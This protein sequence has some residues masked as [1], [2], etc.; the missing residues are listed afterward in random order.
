[1]TDDEAAFTV[2]GAIA[3]QGV[4]L[5]TP[6]LGERFV[7]IGLGLVGLLTVQILRA[8]GC[9]VLGI[10]PDSAKCSLAQRFGADLVR[11]D[12][13]EDPLAVAESFSNGLG[14]DG[15]LIA[16]ATRSNGPIT[17]A[18]RMCR[19]RGRIILVGVVGL[20]LDRNDFYNKEVSFQV[21]CSY[22]PGRYD[23]E[24]ENKG[25]DYPFGFVRWTEQRNFE[26][27]LEMMRL[28]TLDVKSLISHRFPIESASAAYELLGNGSRSQLGIL[29]DY[30]SPATDDREG[31]TVT[32]TT[33]VPHPD[34]R[35]ELSIGFIGAGNYAGRVLIPAFAA[36]DVRLRAIASGKGISA[37]HIGRKF[38]FERATTDTDSLIAATDVDALVIATRHDS[39][40]D[41]VARAL[42]A[43]K[44]VFVEKPLAL[45][46]SEI[47]AIES[48]RAM[49]QGSAGTPHVMVG[50]NRRFAPQIV[51]MKSLLERA[52]D[53]MSIVVTVN[54]GAIP[55]SHWTQDRRVGGGRIIGE[56]CH[57]VDLARFLVA[58]P[59]VDAR[60][61]TLRGN[62]IS[63]RDD[64]ATIN[65]AFRDGS[66]ATIHYLANGHPAF[67]K[68]RIEVFCEG[69]ILQ[70]DN[71][72][73][74][75]GYGWPAFDSMNLWRQ[76]KGQ[77]AC[78]K[79]FVD[80]IRGGGASPIPFDELLEVGRVT[81]ALGEAAQG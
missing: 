32:L 46:A 3:L 44:H 18:A 81:I 78:A 74:L 65:L 41:L 17:Q 51:R 4:R 11:L 42:Q 57:F 54:A 38:G 64:K 62:T 67:P 21:S 58:H 52:R 10:D 36:A 28:G 68:E 75:H 73:R 49:S 19:K 35:T 31:H 72:R 20:E 12:H 37:A 9:R 79:A 22:G 63:V 66:L 34:L 26:A 45:T 40:A 61:Q 23:P 39:H 27:I 70:L 7:V 1:V 77:V 29:L 50:F 14:V 24:Y 33:V 6:T 80:A 16:A 56:C 76:D 60:V 30:P 43:G 69:R 13:G 2:L 8:S 5:A 25:N 15:V 53:P 71:F 59:V 55:S 48:A 47:D